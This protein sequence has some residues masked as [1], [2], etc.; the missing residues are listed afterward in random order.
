MP[1]T[2]L[3]RSLRQFQPTR[4]LRSRDRRSGAYP[5]KSKTGDRTRSG[6][7]AF[8]FDDNRSIMFMS[9]V[10]ITLPTTQQF[11]RNRMTEDLTASFESTVIGDVDPYAVDQ[12]IPHFDLSER[13]GPFFDSGLFEQDE[14]NVVNSKFMTGVAYSIAPDRFK[15]KI[16]N[17]TILRMEFPLTRVSQMSTGSEIMYFNQTSGCFTTSVTERSFLNNGQGVGSF[18]FAPLPFTPYGMAYMP[19][20]DYNLNGNYG[21]GTLASPLPAEQSVLRMTTYAGDGSD[22]VFF[23]IDPGYT[24]GFV[25]ASLLNTAHAAS[26]EQ[27]ISLQNTL[28]HPFLIEKIVVEF[29]F[30]AGPGWLND[31][32]RLREALVS[33]LQYASDGGGPM[34]TFALMR[35][36]GSDLR[37]RDLIASGT[38]TT[39]MDMQTGSY[40]ICTGSYAGVGGYDDICITPDGVAQ[41]G[42]VPSAIITGSVLSGSDNFFSG[43]IRMIMEPQ[44][45]SHVLR[46]RASGSSYFFVPAIISSNNA[47]G[48]VFGSISRRSSKYIESGRSVLGNDFALLDPRK[49]DQRRNPINVMDTQYEDLPQKT[50]APRF[51]RNKTYMDVKSNTIKSPYLLYPQ[52]KL[53]LCLSK[54]RA[55]ADSSITD[56]VLGVMS[57]PSGLYAYHDVAIGTGSIKVTMYGDLIREDIE[58]HDTLNQRLETAELWEDVGE[59]PVLDQFDV[60]YRNELSGCYLDRFSVLGA[61]PYASDVLTSSLEVTQLYSNFSSALQDVPVSNFASWTKGKRVFELAK[62][63]R[64]SQHFSTNEAY[65][66]TRLVNPVRAMKVANPNFTVCLVDAIFSYQSSVIYSGDAQTL[67]SGIS[68]TGA[69]VSEWFM[70]FPFEPKFSGVTTAFSLGKDIMPANFG[71]KI[72]FNYNDIAFELGDTVNRALMV[73][74]FGSNLV[75]NINP[76]PKNEFIKYFYGIGGGYGQHDNQH[77]RGR[78]NATAGTSNYAASSSARIR[79]WKYGMMSGFTQHSKQVYRRDRFGQP[80]DMLEQRLDAKF[81]DELGLSSDGNVGVPIGVKDAPVQVKFYDS[82][83]NQTDSLKTLSS[84]LSFEATSSVPY[85]DLVSRNRLALDFST[86]NITRVVI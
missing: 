34:I 67:S 55:V 45:T 48:A 10:S 24:L 57:D 22:S 78:V 46:T 1:I 80:R 13:P 43:T 63:S 75:T 54:H 65:W 74:D 79:G 47:Y 49:L 38:I 31:S 66:D 9:G 77:V 29:P 28:G 16:S 72:V 52:D 2:F 7:N 39:A 8:Y 26:R 11:D 36:D 15:S 73:G 71:N 19:L 85:T 32:F 42:I 58:F 18:T 4:E 76:L 61:M 6:R 64:A 68:S 37:M 62:S 23:G 83:G 5:V 81:F 59:D 70:G 40:T 17:K 56:V 35:Q 27:T 84:N 30:Q 44:I 41:L 14:T 3:T 60:A 50:T 21:G 51:S 20:N 69:G 33:D 86:L 25:T 82:A 12:F 53:L